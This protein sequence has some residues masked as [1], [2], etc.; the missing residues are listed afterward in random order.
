[1]T[2]IR[3]LKNILKGHQKLKMFD[4]EPLNVE[5]LNA[6]SQKGYI[7]SFGKLT[8]SPSISELFLL[9]LHTI[10]YTCSFGKE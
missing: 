10:S 9:A 4:R 7:L 6:R 5:N 1:M 3:Q 8:S 2:A